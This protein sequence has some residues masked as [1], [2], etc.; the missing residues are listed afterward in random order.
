MTDPHDQWMHEWLNAYGDRLLQFT[1]AYTPDLHTAQDIVQEVFVRLYRERTRRPHRTI[2]A[3]WLY[4]VARRLAVDH[5]RKRA[6]DVQ[7][8]ERQGHSD[9]IPDLRWEV[10]AVLDVLSDLDR[11]L[12]L[13]FYYQEW[14]LGELAAH[15]TIPIETVKSRLHRARNR[16]R[17]AWKGN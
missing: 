3:G 5:Y 9:A 17:S 7:A 1:R 16:F 10:E 8:W 6:R 4:I 14:T 2:R 12:L 11:E 15:Y 13:L